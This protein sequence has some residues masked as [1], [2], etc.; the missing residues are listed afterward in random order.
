MGYFHE[1]Q[2]I[3]ANGDAILLYFVLEDPDSN[4]LL[5][6]ILK[7]A[8]G[9][10]PIDERR[11]YLTG[12]SH[13]GFFAMIFARRH[14]GLV[15]AVATLGNQ[16]GLMEPATTGENVFAT[17][18][19]QLERMAGFDLPV[20]NLLGCHEGGPFVREVHIRSWQRRLKASRCPMRTA[21]EIDA[22]LTSGDKATRI[23]GVPNDKSETL[24]AEG[25]EH[26]IADIRNLDG[27][28][29]LRVVK[30]EGMPHVTT[31]F[32]QSLSWSFMRRFARDPG[33]GNILELC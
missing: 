16:I 15:A 8:A 20:I 3:A 18:D 5:C 21:A 23:L 9:L 12:H 29:H 22:A 30:I 33:T 1:Y 25:F 7:E 32:M 13:D 10:Y 4:D 2:T 17:S 28:F 31:P 19:E 24:Y 26:Y 27:N 6:E 11:V 14:P